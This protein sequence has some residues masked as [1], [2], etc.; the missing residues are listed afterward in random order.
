MPGEVRDNGTNLIGYEDGRGESWQF[1]AKTK[2]NEM[3]V[4]I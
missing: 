3:V 4:S 1:I 2:I